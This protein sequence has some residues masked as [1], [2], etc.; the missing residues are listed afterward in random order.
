MNKKKVFY[1]GLEPIKS[2]YTEQLSTR[3]IPS[4]FEKFSNQIDF[5]PING[6][7]DHTQQIKVGAVLDACGRGVFSM[8]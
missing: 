1:F 5:I 4:A 8:S 2:R 6:I 3:W 7:H